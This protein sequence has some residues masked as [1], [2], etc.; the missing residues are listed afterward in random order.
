MQQP[1]KISDSVCVEMT[2][3]LVFLAVSS[4]KLLTVYSQHQTKT[5]AEL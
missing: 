3:M 4:N 2:T 1:S 5:T